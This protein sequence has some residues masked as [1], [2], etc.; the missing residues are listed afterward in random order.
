MSIGEIMSAISLLKFLHDCGK[1]DFVRR[2]SSLEFI[3]DYMPE[4]YYDA[5][6]EA[7]ETVYLCDAEEYSADKWY[8]AD[9]AMTEYYR[10][11]KKLCRLKG[12]G[13]KRNPYALAAR[14][15]IRYADNNPG[16]N[17]DLQLRTGTKRAQSSHIL[18]YVGYEFY[19]TFD[20]AEYVNSVFDFYREKVKEMRAEYAALTGTKE[21]EA[22]QWKTA[23]R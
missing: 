23:V 21:T 13:K 5:M 6:G 19:E 8:L 18:I 15:F 22:A 7:A 16:Y 10:L 4:L 17:F 14:D 11:A 2:L 1:T 3:C 12:I 9:P 20:L